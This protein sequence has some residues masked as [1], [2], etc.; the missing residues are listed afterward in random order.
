MLAQHCPNILSGLC[1]R[2]CNLLT[3]AIGSGI[4]FED[5]HQ[6]QPTSWGSIKLSDFANEFA[7]GKYNNL[8]SNLFL[9]QFKNC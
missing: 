9:S 4:L 1:N 2:K 3:Q 5:F 6:Q 8:F 7:A